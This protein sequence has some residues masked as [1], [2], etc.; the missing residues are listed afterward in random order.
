MFDVGFWELILVG[1]VALLAF[2]PQELPRLVLD[3]LRLVRKLRSVASVASEELR[4]ELQLDDL[5]DSLHSDLNQ[6]LN[7]IRDAVNDAR[8][9]RLPAIGYDP[10]NPH[11]S[12]TPEQD[13]DERV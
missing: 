13:K 9:T 10:M 1:L 11:K 4:R 7:Q 6:P 12:A 3:T 2:G 8:R 5:D